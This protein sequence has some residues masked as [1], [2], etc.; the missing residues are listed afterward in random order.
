MNSAKAAHGWTISSQTRARAIYC[1]F[2]FPHMQY[3]WDQISLYEPTWIMHA[4]PN[5][6]WMLRWT[7]KVFSFAF[8]W[9]GFQGACT[10]GN[11]Y[12]SYYLSLVTQSWP[13]HPLICLQHLQ[14]VKMSTM[15]ALALS[16]LTLNMIILTS[17]PS[18]GFE[19]ILLNTVES[20]PV[21][22]NPQFPWPTS[23]AYCCILPPHHPTQVVLASLPT[24][25]Y[26]NDGWPKDSY[27]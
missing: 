11:V 7:E 3:L 6:L 10:R 16:D 25:V 27:Q 14:F 24:H 23:T 19:A 9:K 20:M 18:V 12:K 4:M 2:F 13:H 17:A 26:I 15:I 21:L 22:L 8:N 1:W 5:I